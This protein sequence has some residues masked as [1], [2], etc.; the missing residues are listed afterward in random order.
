M[1]IEKRLA[2]SQVEMYATRIE[3]ATTKAIRAALDEGTP[4]QVL[5]AAVAACGRSIGTAV[6][7]LEEMGAPIADIKDV[8]AYNR[9]VGR[10]SMY[11]ATDAPYIPRQHEDEEG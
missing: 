4:N 6:G 5:L 3:I 1:T 8:E 9:E 10:R 7:L 11:E 2:R